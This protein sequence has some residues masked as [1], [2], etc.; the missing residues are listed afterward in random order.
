MRLVIISFTANGAATANR[1]NRGLMGLGHESRAF[2]ARRLESSLQEFAGEAFEE[3]DGMIFIG[4]AGIA[5]RTIAPFLRGK[6]RDPAVVVVDEYGRFS[7]S[8]LSGHI[9]GANDLATAAASILG[10]QPVITTATDLNHAFAVDLFAKKNGFAIADWKEAKEVS[11][12]VLRGEPVG[13]FSDFPVEGALPDPLTQGI[14]QKRNIYVTCYK[15]KLPDA[16]FGC[17]GCEIYI[18]RLIPGAAVLGMGCCRGISPEP[19]MQAAKEILCKS[20]I[21]R[22]ALRMLSSIDL[23]R[24]E[25]ALIGLAAAWKLEWKVFSA[26]ELKNTEGS[27]AKSEFVRHVTGVDN[28]CERSAL[29]GAGMRGRRAHLAAGRNTSPSVTAAVAIEEIAVIFQEGQGF[30]DAG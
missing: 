13:F 11:A 3:M 25:A 19:V 24:D 1:L 30:G 15:D 29:K 21:D 8:L 23:K 22:R 28:V 4:A 16:F 2:S 10:A 9:G 17:S 14:R 5:V 20:G 26:G 18:L 7:I 27:M 12:S 6:D